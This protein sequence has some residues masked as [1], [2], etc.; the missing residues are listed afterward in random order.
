MSCI[1]IIL[2]IHTSTYLHIYI[3]I[4]IY[5]YICAYLYIWCVY[6]TRYIT[7]ARTAS[8]PSC[9]LLP[10]A[11]L[12]IAIVIEL[13]AVAVIVIVIAIITIIITMT[14]IVIIT[15]SN[16]THCNNKNNSNN[17]NNSNGNSNG[18]NDVNTN[19]NSPA[20]C[21]HASMLPCFH[22]SMP[23]C[24][25]FDVASKAQNL[26]EMVDCL[27]GYSCWS[28]ECP[29]SNT[30]LSN[31]MHLLWGNYLNDHPYVESMLNSYTSPSNQPAQHSSSPPFNAQ[32]T[33]SI[34][35]GKLAQRQ[36][37]VRKQLCAIQQRNNWAPTQHSQ[38]HKSWS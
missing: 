14:I 35:A 5:I 38:V 25:H 4:Y 7:R 30:Y 20:S 29:D 19:S 31:L 26:F 13:V 33:R 8:A 21:F 32:T 22:A 16:K 18:N 37:T 11:H 12:L 28:L 36:L 1:H 3:Y 2:Y 6:T 24:L 9:P 27:S 23:P 17:N 34:L 15:N 10:L